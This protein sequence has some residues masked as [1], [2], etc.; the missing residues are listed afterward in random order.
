MY[1][2]FFTEVW[3]VNLKVLERKDMLVFS[4]P[5]YFST[6]NVPSK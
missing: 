6:L 5:E 2:D 3:K 1:F 4:W